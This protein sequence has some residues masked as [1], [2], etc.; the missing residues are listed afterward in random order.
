[1][2]KYNLFL[3]IRGKNSD[4][5]KFISSAF[6]KVQKVL[7]PQKELKNIKTKLLKLKTKLNS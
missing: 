6:K 3:T 5:A 2:K 7:S 1:M 4:G